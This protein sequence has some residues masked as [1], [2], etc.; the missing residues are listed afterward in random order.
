LK[1]LLRTRPAQC[2]LARRRRE[3]YCSPSPSALLTCRVATS[4]TG[5]SILKASLQWRSLHFL[6]QIRIHLHTQ[7]I[8]LLQSN[9]FTPPKRVSGKEWL[10]IWKHL[11]PVSALNFSNCQLPH[12]NS[13]A[14]QKP[15]NS[16]VPSSTSESFA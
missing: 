3:I 9:N 7:L 11:L 10:H 4:F 5:W 1:S 8:L 6:G 2:S 13:N 15:L 12:H 14:V 16:G